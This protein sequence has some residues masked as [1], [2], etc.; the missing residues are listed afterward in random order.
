MKLQKKDFIEI[1]FT[2]R[3]KGGEVFDSNIKE[4]LEKI[5]KDINPKPFVFGLG[6]EMFIKGVDKFL[7]GKEVGKKYEIE[8][9]PTDAFGNR[10]SKLVRLMPMKVFREQKINPVAGA[11][12][13]F[14]G[15]I[16]KILTVS[17]GR[18][19]VDFNNPIAG[20]VVIYNVKVLKKI[21]DMN[22]KVKSL[23]DFLFKKELKFEIKEKKLI[24]EAEKGMTKFIELFKEKFQ[25]TLDLE[26]DVKEITEKK[27]DK[28]EAILP[29]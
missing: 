7:I 26:L 16:A 9:S 27:E 8:L 24:I 12:F 4:D 10:D 23:I 25:N 22:E 5:N 15:R 19:I 14:D 6:E 20:K 17:G 18:I 11:M 3:V 29:Q 2:G 21:E 1:E 28:K 13:N